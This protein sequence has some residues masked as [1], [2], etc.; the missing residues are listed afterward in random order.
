MFFPKLD[1]KPTDSNT[2][3]VSYNRVRWTSPFGVQT[4]SVVARGI[5]S[6]GNDYVHDD[7]AIA[8]WTTSIGTSLT[9]EARFSYS[10]DNEFEF[11]TPALPGEPVS[12]LTGLSPQVD[13]NSCGFSGVTTETP[14]SVALPCGWIFGAPSYLQ[15]AAFPNEQRYQIADNFGISKGR[16][17]I[18]LGFDISHVSDDLNSYASGDQ[19]GEFSYS[20]LQDFLSDYITQANGL[21]GACTS[22]SA[23]PRSKFPATTTTSKRLAR[24][25]LMS[26]L[27]KLHFSCRTIGMRRGGLPSTQDCDLTMRGCLRRWCRTRLFRKPL[28]FRATIRNGHRGLDLRGM[29]LAMGRRHF[30]AAMACSMAASPMNRFTNN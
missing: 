15:R 5:D 6:N 25:H 20:F 12:S 30:A 19:L 1:W 22:T 3:T 10:R 2:I 27:W 26:P 17:L 21:G 9:N 14:T 13:I 7:R 16:H 29:C 28:Y 11:T 23:G 4:G 18:K 24:W 8:S